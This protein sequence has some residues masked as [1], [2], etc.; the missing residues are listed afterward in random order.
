MP[1]WCLGSICCLELCLGPWYCCSCSLWWHPWPMLPQGLIGTMNFESWEPFLDSPILLCPWDSWP[2]FTLKQE[3][4]PWPL[5]GRTGPH[6]Q[7]GW[8]HP[9][10]LVWESWSLRHRPARRAG[11]TAATNHLKGLIPVAQTNQFSHHP[12]EH[13]QSLI[14]Q[15]YISHIIDLLECL[16]WLVLWN[17]SHRISMT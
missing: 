13:P 12:D 6:I 16:K 2:P 7:E 17:N 3:K 10:P 1:W 9:T 8:P 14:R 5:H 4:W 11:S 15:P